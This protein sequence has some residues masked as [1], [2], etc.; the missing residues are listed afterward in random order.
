LDSIG[1][2]LR[3]KKKVGDNGIAANPAAHPPANI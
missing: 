1:F 3:R 2:V